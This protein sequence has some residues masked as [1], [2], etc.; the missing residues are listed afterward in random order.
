MARD[1]KSR[2]KANEKKQN[3]S[4]ELGNFG[5][6]P[7]HYTEFKAAMLEA[8][9]VGVSEY[10]GMLK[11][12]RD[13]LNSYD[14]L[15]IVASFAA[16]G[17]RS[18]VSDSGVEQQKGVQVLQH[19]AELMQAIMLSMPLDQWGDDPVIPSVM[20][21][22]FD[23][24][25]KLTEAF[26][27]Q[28]MLEGAKVT[29]ETLLLVRSLQERISMHTHGVRNWGYYSDVV[30]LSKELFSALDPEFRAHFRFAASD[31]VELLSAIVAEFSRRQSEHFNTL[32]KVYNGKNPRQMARYYFKYVPGLQG[33]PEE[34]VAA[35]PG[36]D[37]KGMMAVIMS[38][39][40]LRL[41]ELATFTAADLA[42][43]TGIP[44][45][46]ITLALRA[47]ALKPGD[48]SEVKVEYFFLDN[49]TWERPVVDLGEFFF[50]PIPQMAFSH[51][52]RIMDRLSADAKLKDVLS[53]TRSR[54]LENKLEETF[55]RLLPGAD[56]RS[57]VKWTVGD[58]QFETDLIVIIDRTAV[59]AEAKSNRLTPE[60]LR[61]APDRVR[62]HVTDMV[63]A[64]SLQS[65]RLTQLI[66]DARNGDPAAMQ[67]LKETKLDQGRIDR[68]IRLSVT[69][70]DLSILT[71]AEA[72]FKA[73]GWAPA[74]H[75][76]A[77]TILISDLG[78]IADILDNPLQV[79]HYLAE[80]SYFQKAFNLL[81][82]E[83]DFLGLYLATGFNLAAM[84][85][86]NNRFVLSGMSARL[87]RY[88]TSRDAGIKVPKPKMNL[89]PLFSRLVNYLAAKRPPGW[90]TIGLH[91]LSC[92]D[93][94][95]QALVE[96]KLEEL[97]GMVRKNFR[98]PQ[99]LSSLKIQPPEDRKAQVIFFLFPH[100]MRATMRQ[101]MEQLAAEA[102]ES[103]KVEA[104]VVFGR[105]VEQWD[106]PYEAVLLVQAAP[107]KDEARGSGI[108]E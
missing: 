55:R 96:R 47:I 62:R 26:Q 45:A 74:D 94:S 78:Y 16:Y 48:L 28:H 23:T 7:E 86:E 64:P 1:R 24:V 9:R 68:V 10:P 65:A 50:I 25:P 88:Y 100:V 99:H 36:I 66:E 77:P 79:L 34:F 87:D 93:P 97:R 81:G 53:T 11:T 33:T 15:V 2:K 63:L 105:S 91:L 80:R 76:L 89:Q 49:P 57:S 21:T 106:R 43:L 12:L 56:I 41:A 44:E 5:I 3:S 20:Q 70:D 72:D 101:D 95:E 73:V 67:V 59:V 98:N 108:G 83:L 17:L 30:S 35:M 32:K 54:F 38:H 40:D 92:A 46:E 102:L 19:H 85:H 69:L 4:I 14:P 104:C 60:G 8:A 18:Y 27:F 31:L 107:T 90:T 29:D 42:G 13:Q 37:R 71:S 6:P 103:D 82:D 51:I 39:Y 61:G 75:N 22:V 84:Q 58:Q 52:H